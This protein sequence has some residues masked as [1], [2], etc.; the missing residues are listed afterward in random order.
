MKNVHVILFTLAIL[1]GASTWSSAMMAAP[2]L[3]QF[4]AVD[5]DGDGIQLNI[6]N[7]IT[8]FPVEY[9]LNGSDS[10]SPLTGN[11]LELSETS[12]VFLR[13]STGSSNYTDR[14]TSM[15]I[16]PDSVQTNY[17]N[18]LLV[19]WD[20]N[21]TIGYSLIAPSNSDKISPDQPTATPIPGAA[22]LFA[23]GLIGMVAARK[24]AR[25]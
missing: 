22:W 12:Q 2:P 10:W 4:W 17:F 25:T 23:S 20:P 24:K 3:V 14:G 18:S 9:S 5:A 19:Q 8:P 11:Q 7:L 1:F 13:L 21:S 15:Y 16:G 6:L